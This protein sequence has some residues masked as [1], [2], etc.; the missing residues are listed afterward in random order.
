MRWKIKLFGLEVRAKMPV[1][2]MGYVFGLQ[3]T[4]P[5][6]LTLHPTGFLTPT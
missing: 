6:L 2:L 1:L 5:N 4:S 3:K